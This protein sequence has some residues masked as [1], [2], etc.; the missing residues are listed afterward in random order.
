MSGLALDRIWSD[1]YA[2]I[3]N[4]PEAQKFQEVA[5]KEAAEELRKIPVE[6]LRKREFIYIPNDI[7]MLHYFGSEIADY[8][9]GVYSNDRCNMYKRLVYPIKGFNGSVVALGGWAND[10]DYKYVY[11]PDTLWDKTRYLYISPEEFRSALDDDYLILIDGIFDSINL[12]RL[13]L[14]AASLMGS[15]F[16]SWH[17]QYIKMFK[18]IIVIPDND[19]A[20]VNLVRKIKRYRKDAIALWQGEYK[21]IDDYIKNKDTKSLVE[22][23]SKLETMQMLRRVVVK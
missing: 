17:R 4:D 13:G 6:E 7:Y 14:H 9:Y 8:R 2:K 23:C 12:N 11:S 19:S 15:N 1:G 22:Q 5:L 16:S 20:G 10:S 21:D 3:M 18:Y